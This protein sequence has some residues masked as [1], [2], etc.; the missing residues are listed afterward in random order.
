MSMG[1]VWRAGQ[2]FDMS[3]AADKFLQPF[4]LLQKAGSTQSNTADLDY[5]RVVSRR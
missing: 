5:I 4:F 3:A 1:S 2:V